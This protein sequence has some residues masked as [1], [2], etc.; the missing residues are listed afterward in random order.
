LLCLRGAMRADAADAL[1][2]AICHIHRCAFGA[3]LVQPVNGHLQKKSWRDC[4]EL[5]AKR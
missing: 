2:A 1:A 3:R 5:A 4:L